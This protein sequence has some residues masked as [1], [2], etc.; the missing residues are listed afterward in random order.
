CHLPL[1]AHF[2][3]G[4]TRFEI[5]EGGPL[6]GIAER[7]L[8]KLHA[9]DGEPRERR[10]NGSGPSTA[11]LSRWFAALGKLNYW[12]TSLQELYV[13][14]AGCAV[15]AIGLDGAIVCRLRDSQWEIAAS[16]LPQPELG[17]HVDPAVLHEVLTSQATLFHSA[18]TTRDHNSSKG[19]RSRELPHESAA[20]PAVVA[21]PLRNAAGVIVGAIYGYRSIRSGN[22]R[23]GI[24]YLEAHWIE[25]LA[26]AVSDA[27]L[28]LERDSQVDRRRALL[29]R[30]AA[31]SGTDS[32]RSLAAETR[33]VTLL[34]ADLRDFT[35]RA[36]TLDMD[37]VYELLG[38]V[39]D[40]LTAAVMDH[41]GLVLDYYGDGLAAM[42]NAPADQADH[43]ELACRAA[44]RMLESLPDVTRDWGSLID[45]PLQLGVGLHTGQARVG[46]AGSRHRTKYGPRGA[47]VNLTSRV[48]AATKSIGIPLLATSAVAAQLANSIVTH[49]VCTARLPGVETPV[50]LFSV[51]TTANARKT[52]REWQVYCH[53]LHSFESDDLQSAADA[54]AMLDPANPDI[55]TSFLSRQIQREIGR[56]QNRRSTD[57]AP[58][59]FDGVITLTAK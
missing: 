37:V 48:E 59:Q 31:G 55:P 47:N 16:H 9:D 6:P 34:F 52:A 10:S 25:L 50:E 13:Q 21:S 5:V 51:Q 49:R 17:I 54:V 42:W 11:T 41:D 38:S 15:E 19:E 29:E 53:A 40:V 8:Q 44:L 39:M 26:G 28:R 46:N 27:M 24:R 20:P 43:A 58:K 12:A 33:E 7:P 23:R 36:E 2:K 4:D 45:G 22:A 35:R 3:I 30:T 18:S 56:Q 32:H 1:P 57:R 14:A